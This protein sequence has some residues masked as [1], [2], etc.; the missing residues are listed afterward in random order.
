MNKLTLF[1]S[2]LLFAA[3]TSS[4]KVDEAFIT[5][6]DT[7]LKAY[8]KKYQELMIPASEAAWKLNTYIQE[9]DTVTSKQAEEGTTA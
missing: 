3:C 2:L 9:G 1:I 5:E 4:P 8:N 7:Y 6:V